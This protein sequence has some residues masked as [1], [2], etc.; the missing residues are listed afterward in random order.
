MPESVNVFVMN[1]IDHNYDISDIHCMVQNHVAEGGSSTIPY[2]RDMSFATNYARTLVV[3]NEDI[4][5]FFQH[6]MMHRIH[7]LKEY[8]GML[9]VQQLRVKKKI[10]TLQAAKRKTTIIHHS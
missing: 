9:K 8:E 5:Y 7:V 6:L 2:I 3:Q 4:E 1:V 10:S